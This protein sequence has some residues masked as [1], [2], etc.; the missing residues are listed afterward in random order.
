MT[1]R[2]FA[3]VLALVGVVALAGCA[4]PLPVPPAASPSYW[5][6]RLS[7]RV[8]AEPVQSFAAGF[9]LA[10]DARQ[11]RLSLQS[12]FGATL[13]QLSWSPAAA[14]LQSE[15]KSQAFSSLDALTRHVVGTE[16]PIN[17][18]F[19]WLRG[20][21]ADFSPWISDG[22]ERSSGRLIARRPFP[23]PVVEMRLVLE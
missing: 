18:I 17:G 21:P 11:G 14:E 15:G 9:E 8:D 5:V 12:P 19:S 7:V 16:L 2:R 3:G 23:L 10:G 6:G 1:T 22:Q 20:E 4:S 13:A